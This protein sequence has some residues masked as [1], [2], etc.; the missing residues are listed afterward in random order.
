MN[1]AALLNRFRAEAVATAT[2]AKLLT[3]LYDRLVLDL[4][5]GIAAIAADDRA[6]VNTHLNHAQD[7]IHELRASL[8]LDAW[9]GARG[10]MD[11]YNYIFVELVSANIARDAA[12]VTACRDLL[13]PLRDAW[14]EAAASTTAN[15][16]AV[17]AAPA[18]APRAADA[19]TDRRIGELGVA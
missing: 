6:A 7:I 13:I 15:G 18:A 9:D 2:P 14:H 4:D 16:A 1:Q 3:M 5:R 8:D 11:L 12:R 10:L 17:P 19:A